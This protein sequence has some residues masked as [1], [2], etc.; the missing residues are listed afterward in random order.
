VHT[1][2]A[3]S[4][5]LDKGWCSDVRIVIGDDGLIQRVE[6][7]TVADADQQHRGVILPGIANAHSHAF[8][9]ALAGRTESIA[10]AVN[11][12]SS[13]FWSWRDAMYVLADRLDPDRLRAI[14]EL[15]YLE[16]LET[17][18]TSVAEF[19]YLHHA[20]DGKPFTRLARLAE[21]HVEAA[22]RV[23]I[24]LVL[25][26]TLYVGGSFGT[27]TLAS[28]QR[29]FANSTAMFLKLVEELRTSQAAGQ[30]G[31]GLHS[32]R[33]VPERA[34][35]EVV[36]FAQSEMPDAP[37]HIHIAEQHREVEEC[38]AF[39]GQ[40]PVDWLLNHC[41][42]DK[43]WCLVHATHTTRSELA[44][45][46]QSG[47]T[48]VLCP[49][50]EA[51]LG[52]GVFRFVEFTR[53]GGRFAIGSDSQVS[54]DPWQELQ[55]LE[56]SQRLTRHARNVAASGQEPHTGAALYQGALAGGRNSIRQ[57]CGRIAEGWAADL[58][59]LNTA[60]PRLSGLEGDAL[61]D[62]L[63]F[64]N[65]KTPIDAVMVAGRWRVTSGRHEHRDRVITN[66]QR[67][68]AGL[69]GST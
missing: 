24:R 61:L 45:I 22:E 43:R 9:R 54:V 29:R 8:Q 5:Y 59:V 65:P 33:A 38:L 47:A 48:V 2:H 67:A 34:V 11:R 13:D 62:S 32:L 66:F 37:I 26:P 58:L 35:K 3:K 40:R 17:G 52:D 63:I 23:G 28:A 10:P 50:T 57:L 12:V 7:D 30:V 16:M 27:K 19:H 51:N 18:Y 14:A 15:V 1:I 44:D 56:Y 53:H 69:P 68:M 60:D 25:I 6:K 21:I 49:T 20:T 39:T 64:A 42:I 55:L 36:A 46:A 31:I 4:A 41:R